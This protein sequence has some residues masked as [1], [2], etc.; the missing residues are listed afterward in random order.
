MRSFN[1]YIWRSLSIAIIFMASVVAFSAQA[2]T[3]TSGNDYPTTLQTSQ[4]ANHLL[5]FTTPSGVAEGET[6]IITFASDFDTSSLTE[7]DVDI[8]DDSTDLTTAADCTGSEQ[9]SVGIS[10]DVVTITICTGDGGAMA[11]TSVV[12]VEIGSNATTSG[13]GSNQI[14]NPSSVATYYVSIAGTF[15]DSGSIALPMGGD[16]SILVSAQLNSTSGVSGGTGGGSGGPAESADTTAPVISDILVSAITSSSAVVTWTTDETA[17][18]EFDFGLTSSFELGTL[19]EEGTSVSHSIELVGLDEGAEI[20]FRVRSSDDSSNEASSSTQTFSTLDEAGPVISDIEVVDIGTTSVRVTWTTDEVANSIVSYGETAGYGFAEEDETYEESH[21]VILTELLA[22]TTYHFQLSSSDLSANQTLSDDAEF[23][24]ATD[25]APTNVS[26]LLIAEGDT[27]LGLSWTN[28]EEEDLAGILVLL[29]SD[30]SPSAADDADCT[31]VFDELGESVDLTG[32]SNGTTYYVGIFAY[33]AAGQFASGALGTGTPS[34]SVEDL[35]S[36]DTESGEEPPRGEDSSD[37]MGVPTGD[38]DTD[39]SEDTSAGTA[40]SC[41]DAICSDTESEDSCPADCAIDDPTSLGAEAGEIERD[42]VSYLVAGD[43]LELTITD[44]GVI[45][46]LPTSTLSINVPTAT[47]SDSTESVTLSI[48]LE[49]YLLS[50]TDETSV[51]YSADVTTPSISATYLVA[52]EGEGEDGAQGVSSFLRVVQSGHTYEDID[53]EEAFVSGVTVTLLQVVDDELIVWDGSPYEQFNPTQSDSLGAFAWYVPNGTYIVQAKADGYEDYETSVIEVENSIVNPSILMTASMG[54]EVVEEP[55]TQESEQ[56]AVPETVLVIILESPAV[57][58]V[59]ESLE[60][61]RDLPG[62][63]EAAEMSIPTLAVTAGASVVVL[64][65]A[66]DFLPFLQYLFTAPLLFF[67]RRKRKGY[68]VIYNAISKTPVDLAVVR[69][70]K[71]TKDDEASGK[72]G[73]L[74]K[75]RVTDKGG[76]YFFLVEPGR[77]RLQVTK[78]GFEFPST[79]LGKEKQDGSF[80]DLYHGEVIEVTAKDAVI[81]ANLP[82]DPSQADKFQA[83]ASVVR[84]KKLRALQ[85]STAMIGVIASIVFAIIRPTPFAIGMIAIQITV[86]ALAKRLAKPRKP[87][88]WGIVYDKGTGRPLSRVVARIFEPKYNKLLETQVTD[89]KGRYA[90]LLGPNQYYAVFQKPGFQK[91]EITPIDYSQKS[92]PEDFSADVRLAPQ[93]GDRSQAPAETS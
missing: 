46:V 1:T 92:S 39:D 14:V 59:Q 20:Y 77:Y 41:G 67:W 70:F 62:V 11:A 53:G 72:P 44:S 36:E 29:C 91:E 87:I 2:A 85:H 57:K 24:T 10:S 7:D 4:S 47:L 16:D 8:T 43:E 93:S 50:Q 55:I 60:V 88:S 58:V 80:L 45:D 13:T 19:S 76:R 51:L 52:I 35:P 73:R 90:F 40:V 26:G 78:P 66:F 27:T 5:S 18:G 54:V 32:L 56:E 49:S 12:D 9:A 3:L 17:T 89:A 69:L 38:T 21:S 61:I 74:V 71:V 42:D 82:M 37:G 64:S 6:I 48:G 22:G 33:D 75:S 65:I 68:G 23:S 81:T 25:D 28:P 84:R 31:N 83:P 63:E 30:E 79:Y 15:G 86:F 34:A